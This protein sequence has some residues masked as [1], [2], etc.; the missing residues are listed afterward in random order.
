MRMDGGSRVQENAGGA[1]GYRQSC[2]VLLVAAAEPMVLS[3]YARQLSNEGSGP[4]VQYVYRRVGDSL[5]LLV[6][7]WWST[8]KAPGVE[9][10][11]ENPACL[12]CSIAV[13]IRTLCR[14]GESVVDE[15]TAILPARTDPMHL[16]MRLCG[17]FLIASA[18]AGADL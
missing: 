13:D 15:I 10:I 7:R 8:G 3:E 16:A 4:V 6:R 17:T 9:V 2:V 1:S 14:R 11:A 12:G 5:P 18:G